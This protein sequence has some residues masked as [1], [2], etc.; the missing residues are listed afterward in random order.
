MEDDL[1]RGAAAGERGDAAFDLLAGHE[2]FVRL[3]DLHGVSQRAGGA[4]D[5]G[6]LLHGCG[7]R[8]FCSD[9]RV[10]DLVVGHGALFLVGEDGIFLLIACDDDLDALL[11]IGLCDD[12]ASVA[13]GAQRAFVDHVGQ[14]RAGSAGGHA[15]DDLQI[16]VVGEAHL[17]CV[18]LQNGDAPL[19]IGQLHGHAA[20]KPA[21]PRERGVE[22]FGA[23]RRGEDDDA[24]VALK[25]IHLRQKLVER[26]LALVVAAEP[27]AVALLADGV[28]LVDEH[29]ARRFLLGLLEQVANLGCAHADEH[30]HE[31]RAGH[32]EKRHAR[33]A[34]HGL[35]QHRLTGTRRADQ[36]HTLGHRRAHLGVFLRV[37]QIVHDLGKVFLRLVLARHIVKPDALRRGDVDLGV[38]LSHAE[39]HGVS[40]ASGA[41]QQLFVHVLANADEDHQRQQPREQKAQQGGH[42]GR[43]NFGECRAGRIQALGQTGIVHCAGLVNFGAVLIGEQ[44]FVVL[45]FNFADLLPLRHAHERAVVHFFDPVLVDERH[46][47]KIEQQQRREHNGVIK[48]QRLFRFLDLMHMLHSSDRIFHVL[49]LI[50]TCVENKNKNRKEC[51]KHG[52]RTSGAV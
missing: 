7:V 1:L 17:A 31:F 46:G 45:D 24:V 44:D 19:Q 4:G 8:L 34:G 42:R 6:D 30:F 28:D 41:L 47:Q 52:A 51:K 50:C 16:H 20:V 10:A 48:D 36:Q 27:A 26:L 29:D 23:V 3:L 43:R 35:G 15:R 5:D 49:I 25:A 9:E 32:G 13:H 11:Q 21:G 22:R 33:L 38:A 39:H 12:L 14:L 2:I 40:A 37:V 18:H